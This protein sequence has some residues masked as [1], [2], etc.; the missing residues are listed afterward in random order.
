[1][2]KA[3]IWVKAEN[4]QPKAPDLLEG[5]GQLEHLIA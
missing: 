2:N 5:K 4:W 1:M 3:E